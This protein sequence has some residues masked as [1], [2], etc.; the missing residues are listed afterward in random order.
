MNILVNGKR[1]DLPPDSTVLG[2]LTNKGL[3]PSTVVVEL[4]ADIVPG[5]QY[6]ETFLREGDR[7]EVLRFVGGG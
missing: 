1:T 3:D 5:A 2:L 6:A 7:L 4:N